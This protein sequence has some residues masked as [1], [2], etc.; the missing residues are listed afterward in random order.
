MLCIFHEKKNHNKKTTYL[1]SFLWKIYISLILPFLM[2]YYLY[3]KVITVFYYP[4][5]F[6]KNGKGNTTNSA[7][8]VIE[9]SGLL[10]LY[11]FFSSNHRP[12]WIYKK[13]IQKRFF[14]VGK[15]ILIIINTTTIIP[16]PSIFFV[17][18][19]VL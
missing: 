18:A 15:N 11:C 16:P 1:F 10:F 14:C 13:T 6:L 8:I 12:P 4:Y 7:K 5:N 19:F 2:A 9:T 17:N 3:L